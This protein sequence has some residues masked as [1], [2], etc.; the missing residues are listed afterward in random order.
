MENTSNTRFWNLTIEDSVSCSKETFEFRMTK[1]AFYG[2]IFVISFIGNSCVCVVV[3][4]KAGMKTVMNYFLVNLA[5]ADLAFTVICIPF[6]LPVQENGYKWPFHESLCKVIFPLQ[7][8][9]AFASVFTLAAIS[10]SRFRAVVHPMKRQLNLPATRAVICIIWLSSLV[11]VIPYGLVLRVNR[12]TNQCEEDWP[13]PAHLY[14]TTYTISIFIAQYLIP[15]ALIFWA[16]VRIYF[17]MAANSAR[18]HQCTR[19]EHAIETRKVLRTAIAVTVLFAICMLPNHIVWV[20]M[21]FIEDNSFIGCSSWLVVANICVFANSAADPIVYTVFHEKYRKEF[22]RFA[23]GICR[24]YTG[25]RRNHNLEVTVTYYGN[26]FTENSHHCHGNK[27][28]LTTNTSTNSVLDKARDL[29]DVNHHCHGNKVRL[30]VNTS[31]NSVLDD[32]RDLNDG[33]RHCHGNKVRLTANT[34][35]NS[36]LDDTR[37]LNDGNHH[38]HGNKLRLTTNTSTNSVLDKARDLNDGNH[39]CHGNK[40]RISPNMSTNLVLDDTNKLNDSI[41]HCHG[42]NVRLIINT[43]S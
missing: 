39:H 23:T 25:K 32:T 24:L 34:S 27:M 41:H 8:M 6:D 33:N 10:L 20:M 43:N 30:T 38:C 22:V 36:V 13:Q 15:L 42:N 37:D 19:N 35:T 40:L 1:Y 2:V 3:W 7:T 9:C 5:V 31:T 11:F 14:R 18:Y 12:D 17:E 28:R 4:R 26:A 29:N 16:Y 21:D